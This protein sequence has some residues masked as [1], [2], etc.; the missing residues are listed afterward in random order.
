MIRLLTKHS[1]KLRPRRRDRV[2]TTRDCSTGSAPHHGEKRP[3]LGTADLQL[4]RRRGLDSAGRRRVESK[5]VVFGPR[6]G[7]GLSQR[8]V[9]RRRVRRDDFGQEEKVQRSRKSRRQHQGNGEGRVESRVSL[10]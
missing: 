5:L 3:N 10:S 4:L 8:G 9:R 6:R 1:S 7:Q 2:H